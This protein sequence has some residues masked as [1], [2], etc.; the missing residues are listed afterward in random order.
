MSS[1][2]F[3]RLVD[4]T[5]GYHCRIQKESKGLFDEPH[6]HNMYIYIWSYIYVSILFCIWMIFLNIL[7]FRAVMQK[8]SLLGLVVGVMLFVFEHVCYRCICKKSC[9]SPRKRW[10]RPW[11]ASKNPP[12]QARHQSRVEWMDFFRNR[13]FEECN[14]T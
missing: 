4:H 12:H 9:W 2:A 1:E 7:L 6:A 3:E 11:S 13:G 8:T 14:V 10:K 5:S